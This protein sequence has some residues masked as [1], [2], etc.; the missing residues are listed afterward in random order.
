METDLLGIK[1]KFYSLG[2]EV[3]EGTEASSNV[4]V[5]LA[6]SGL[7]AVLSMGS[8]QQPYEV[9]DVSTPYRQETGSQ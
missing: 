2:M 3:S 5:I 8:P 9:G 7:H 6:K 1:T 4:W